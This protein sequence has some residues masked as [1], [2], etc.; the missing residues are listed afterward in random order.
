MITFLLINMQAVANL[1][2][3]TLERGM[4]TPKSNV[5][6]FG[7]VLLELLTG[8]KNLDSRHPKEEMNLVKWSRPYLADDCRLSLIMDP[9]L[10]GRFPA[11][12]AR[13][14]ADIAQ[15][16]LQKDP[17]E[18]P[19][20]RTVV[21]HLKSIQ[22]MKYS[23][24]FPLQDPAAFAG[25]HMSRSPSLNGIVTPA[26]RLS[27]SPSP[28]SK[29]R[30]SVSPTRRPALPI[31]LLPPRGCSTIVTMEELDHLLESRKSSSSTVPRAS[32]EGF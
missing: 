25:K 14:M 2:M 6:S 30:P 13:A 12:A 28:P 8:R 21:E 5:W 22:D 7:I 24:R 31:S 10:K 18:R 11:K 20:M 3:E 32:V 1:S 29:A 17:S 9:Q 26:P 16:C 15:R 4:L 27:F 19:T 23:C